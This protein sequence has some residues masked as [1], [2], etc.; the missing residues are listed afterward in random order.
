[1]SFR[2]K[3][4]CLYSGKT[5]FEVQLKQAVWTVPADQTPALRPD[6]RGCYKPLIC[7]KL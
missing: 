3:P 4:S 2:M 7:E 5:P 6:I 1:M